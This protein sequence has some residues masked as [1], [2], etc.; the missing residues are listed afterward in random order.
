MEK[1]KT[2]NGG[3]IMEWLVT[4]VFSLLLSFGIDKYR[5]IRGK[6]RAYKLKKDLKKELFYGILN[7][8]GDEV[9]Y[10]DLDNFLSRNKVISKII[11][12][13]YNTP[14]SQYKSKN[15]L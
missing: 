12:N 3:N 13:A 14:V 4:E 2:T 11:E 15:M 10:N 8:Y 6:I 7:R 5:G 1:E 9:Y